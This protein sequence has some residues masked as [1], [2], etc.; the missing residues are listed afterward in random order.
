LN[1]QAPFDILLARSDRFAQDF[2]APLAKAGGGPHVFDLLQGNVIV[3]S[4]AS[5]TQKGLTAAERRRIRAAMRALDS[6]T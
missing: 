3:S 4:V 5:L 2:F 1:E 6:W